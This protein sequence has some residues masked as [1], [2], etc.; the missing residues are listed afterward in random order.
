MSGIALKVK[1]GCNIQCAGCYESAIFERNDNHPPPYD[2]D[3]VE[4]ASRR[5]PQG[6]V[7]FHGGEPLLVPIADMRRLCEEF[8]RQ[9]R[10]INIQTNAILLRDEHIALF[11]EY[12]VGVGISL[13][14]PGELNRD[15]WVG[16]PEATDRATERI[17]ANIQRL[18]AEGI[19]VSLICVLSRTNAG[20]PDLLE[21]LITWGTEMGERHQVWWIRFNPL[22]GGGPIEL[23]DE[24]AT[25]AYLRL[26]AATFED[27]R[28]CW[29]PFREMLD[30]L[31]G[32]G[33]QPCWL[34]S[35]DVYATDAV[36][37]ILADGST[38]NCMRTATDGV[39]YLRTRADRS[40]RDAI[41][42]AI[43]MEQAGCGGCR[44]W[45][46]CT[47]GCPAEAVD[48][49]WRNKTRFCGMTWQTYAYIEK[50]MQG[51]LPNWTPVPDWTTNDEADLA[52]SI[53]RREPKVNAINPADPRWSVR[54]ST[55]ETSAR[56][57]K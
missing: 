9:G 24:E 1:M 40:I 5:G 38:G 15:R 3:A 43:P 45:R 48:G 36:Y 34:A 39:T 50:R 52:A 41:L 57:T 53:Q 33:L 51:L 27:R 29:L 4:A 44:Y 46:V 6:P 55:F 37:A 11:K 22:Y 49:D 16:S 10:Q 30:N 17:Q 19:A 35:C 14:G 7:V 31:W 23:S 42:R 21:R 32:L 56:K 26:C 25:A 28:R 20:A 2:L 18:R 12:R 8:S 13:N 47:G 54:P